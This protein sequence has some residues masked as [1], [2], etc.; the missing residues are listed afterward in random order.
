[1]RKLVRARALV[2]GAAAV[3]LMAGVAAVVAVSAAGPS[4]AGA[5][6]HLD[7]P[8]LTPPGG[9]RPT[10]ITDIYAFRAKNGR[11]VLVDERQ[12]LHEAAGKQATFATSAP[13]VAANKRVTYNLRVDNNG[14][15]KQD[16]TL[17]RHVR[18]A[19]RQ[20]VQELT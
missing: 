12:R 18:H 11:T 14:D 5:A 10:D 9:E 4:S 6:D 8:N 20:G 7:A 15:A 2:L 3:V 13:S 16:V 1:M 19:E 17:A